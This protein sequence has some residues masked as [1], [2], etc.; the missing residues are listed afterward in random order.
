MIWGTFL[1]CQYYSLSTFR[2]GGLMAQ[3]IE[4]AYKNTKKNVNTLL[5]YKW[6]NLHAKTKTKG[7]HTQHAKDKPEAGTEF[8]MHEINIEHSCKNSCI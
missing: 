2:F 8:A 4:P 6:S 7:V 3:I 5:F 1:K